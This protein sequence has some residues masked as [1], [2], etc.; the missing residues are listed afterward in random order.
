MAML[1]GKVNKGLSPM[2][3]FFVG[4]LCFVDSTNC[5]ASIEIVIVETYTA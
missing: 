3:F 4:Y 2:D 1:N 5:V